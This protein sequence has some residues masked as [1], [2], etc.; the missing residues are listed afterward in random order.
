M[1]ISIELLLTITGIL[2]TIV[3][4]YLGVRYTIRAKNKTE[5]LFLKNNSISLFENIV[6]NLEGIE[7]KYNGEKVDESLYTVKGTFIN[8]G[9][10]DIDKSLI[11]NP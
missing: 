9:N 4:G 3:I 6:K 5:L 1:E 10:V 2:L 11:H 7:I 8:T